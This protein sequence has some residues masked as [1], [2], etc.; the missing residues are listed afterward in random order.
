M[1][2]FKVFN[3]VDSGN[4]TQ[5]AISSIVSDIFNVNHDYWGTTFTTVAKVFIF[6]FLIPTD[7]N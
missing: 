7:Y 6:S 5:G 1:F 2:K 3:V 4:T